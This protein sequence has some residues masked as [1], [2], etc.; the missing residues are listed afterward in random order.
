MSSKTMGGEVDNEMVMSFQTSYNQWCTRFGVERIAACDAHVTKMSASLL[1]G[2]N[3]VTKLSLRRCGVTNVQAVALAEALSRFPI[4]TKIDLRDNRLTD[5][6]A[7]A[8]GQAMRTQCSI[9]HQH[10][11]RLTSH[12]SVTLNQWSYGKVSLLQKL[13]LQGNCVYDPPLLASLK[14]Q[15]LV[16]SEFNSLAR[17]R[18]MVYSMSRTENRSGVTAEATTT[19]TVSLHLGT[20]ICKKLGVSNPKKFLYPPG[21][22]ET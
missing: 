1:S 6:G 5:E 17:L 3:C 4:F 22:H 13:K 14:Q 2:K 11:E 12:T 10:Y 16:S 7:A 18:Y 21:V 15:C 9:M 20:S 19:T 8:L